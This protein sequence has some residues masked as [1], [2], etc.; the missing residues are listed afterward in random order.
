MIAQLA[1]FGTVGVANTMLTAAT[2]AALRAAGAPA[3]VAAPIGFAVGGANG[4]VCNGRWTFGAR[5]RAVFRRYVAVQL[6]ALVATDAILAA[7][8]PY[9]LVL[10]T[11]TVA[12]FV[13]CR[14]WAFAR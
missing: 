5:S 11:V 4:Y 13:A 1:R 8:V 7:G 14:W 10:G 6:G 2:Y 12:A 3:L 9:V